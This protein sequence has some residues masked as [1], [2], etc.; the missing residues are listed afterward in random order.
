MHLKLNDNKCEYL[1]IHISYPSTQLWFGQYND[2][3]ADGT[4]NN[5]GTQHIQYVSNTNYTRVIWFD[6]KRN[7]LAAKV[8]N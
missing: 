2:T 5:Y 3:Y 7:D 8:E 6:E 1:L 4:I